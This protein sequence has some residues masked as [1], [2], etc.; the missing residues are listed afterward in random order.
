MDEV[1]R[2]QFRRVIDVVLETRTAVDAVDQKVD[3]LREEVRATNDRILT[4]M[5]S[6][7]KELRESRRDH[8]A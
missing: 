2:E 6:M 7:S 4:A 8:D 5:D 1:T 3:T